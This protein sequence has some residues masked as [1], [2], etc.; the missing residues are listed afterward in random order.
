MSI[1]API[2]SNIISPITQS[3]TAPFARYLPKFVIA[4]SQYGDFNATWAPTGSDWEVVWE[5]VIDVAATGTT[6]RIA[7]GTA[8][9]GAIVLQLTPAGLPQ[10]VYRDSSGSFQAVTG[11]G[12]Q[13]GR[14][15]TLRIKASASGVELYV[16]NVLAG[17]NPAVASEP[18]FNRIC[19]NATPAEFA[20]VTVH[21]L[22]FI[23]LND[24]TNTRSYACDEASGDRLHDSRDAT[25]AAKYNFNGDSYL[26][27]ASPVAMGVGYRVEFKFDAPVGGYG[28][29][30]LWLTGSAVSAKLIIGADGV[31]GL[32]GWLA[33]GD[34]VEM[35]GALISHAVTTAPTD[36]KTHTLVLTAGDIKEI[37]S[38]AW[39]SDGSGSECSFPIYEIRIYDDQDTLLHHWPV[40]T[41]TQVQ[42]DIVKQA[43]LVDVSQPIVSVPIGGPAFTNYSISSSNWDVGQVYVVSFKVSEYS[44]TGT[45]AIAGN[46]IDDNLS[47]SGDGTSTGLVTAIGS[48]P[49]QLFSRSSNQCVFSDITVIRY[50]DATIAGN[51]NPDNHLTSGDNDV[52]L[53]N[54]VTRVPA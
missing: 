34:S 32:A 41:R 17:S 25:R 31:F 15:L 48:G 54:G 42:R 19:A 8:T 24:D 7:F 6:Q 29:S 20:G 1:T 43:E 45:V 14:F 13:S 10:I 2:I 53:Q 16:N 44:G 3:I 23:D 27:L 11:S 5:G 22:Q 21:R 52:I 38:F 4:N 49:I 46:N 50:T 51:Y 37:A 9:G 12:V 47:I 28:G 33:S 40:N 36:G 39:S 30:E 35:D 26:P 18:V